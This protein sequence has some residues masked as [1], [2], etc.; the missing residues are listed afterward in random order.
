M[1]D[2]SISLKKLEKQKKIKLKLNRRKQINVKAENNEIGRR[3]IL[4][5]INTTKTFFFEK[6]KNVDKPSARLIIK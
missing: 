1:Y 5:N 6:I 4:E 3:K 2:L